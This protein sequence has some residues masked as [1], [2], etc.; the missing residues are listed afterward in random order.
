MSITPSGTAPRR[1]SLRRGTTS[2]RRYGRSCQP[3]T[4][5]NNNGFRVGSTLPCRNSLV[6]LFRQ[7]TPAERARVQNQQT[8]SGVDARKDHLS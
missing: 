7:V 8:A 1:L 3:D 2:V 4:G 5:N 6:M